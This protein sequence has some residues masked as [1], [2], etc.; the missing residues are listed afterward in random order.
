MLPPIRSHEAPSVPYI[1]VGC[2]GAQSL[3]GIAFGFEQWLDRFVTA[4]KPLWKTHQKQMLAR[5]KKEAQTAAQGENVPGNLEINV[6]R[7]RKSPHKEVSKA[8]GLQTMLS[9]SI[10]D[11]LLR[12]VDC[13]CDLEVRGLI[14]CCFRPFVF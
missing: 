6:A 11:L 13:G 10:L 12:V 2:C 4:W 5:A 1:R 14:I 3:A 9:K 8:R 7:Q